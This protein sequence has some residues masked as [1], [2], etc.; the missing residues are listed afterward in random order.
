MTSRVLRLLLLLIPALASAQDKDKPAKHTLRLLPLGDPPPFLQEVRNGVRYEIPAAE[1]TIPP[2]TLELHIPVEKGEE[3]SQLRLRLGSAS[4]P[5]EFPLPE[6]KIV[7]ARQGNNVWAKIPLSTSEASLALVWRGGADWSKA[8][9]MTIPDGKADRS[10]GDCR[11]VNLTAKPLGLIW[12][13]ERLKLE[14][15]TT[16]VR[17]IP[18]G[19][20]DLAVS[21]LFPDAKNNPRPC[22]ATQISRRADKLQQFFIYA[23]D[24]KEARM[25]VKVLPLEEDR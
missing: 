2:R 24:E 9:V 23:S 13:T 15:R 7:E 12:G 22:L 17:S 16:L 5:L 10:K 20:E 1:G 25:P 6:T 8:G 14:P 18:A 21:I 3:T 4:S 19:T 11:F